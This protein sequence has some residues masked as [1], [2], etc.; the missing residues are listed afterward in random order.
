MP[1]NTRL[2]A[3]IHA[4][5]DVDFFRIELSESALVLTVNLEGGN[6]RV[7][8]V[9][10]RLLDSN[11]VELPRERDVGI[12]V[13]RLDAGI[14]YI[15]A[16]VPSQQYE[17]PYNIQAMTIPD[18]GDTFES[19]A[20]LNLLADR[21]SIV[22]GDLDYMIYGDFH[23]PDDVDFFKV[24]LSA[25]AE[26]TIDFDYP[27]WW[28]DLI[29]GLGLM[30]SVNL[31][32]FDDEGNPLHP[33]ISGLGG[34]GNRAYSLEAGT[35]YFRLST[36]PFVREYMEDPRPGTVFEYRLWLYGNAEYAQ[37]IDECSSVETD[38]DDP[39]VGCQGHL[40]DVNVEDV[41]A[42]NKGEGINI[43]VVDRTIESAHPDLRDNVKE[44]LNHD[45]TEADQIIN[46]RNSHATA[47]AGIIAARD[48]AL[49]VRGVAGIEDC[50][51]DGALRTS[52][53]RMLSNEL[54]PTV[55]GPGR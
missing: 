22:S 52:D 21:A 30:I 2:E 23:S 45:Y 7:Y 37:F 27:V 43:A 5:D 50:E 17:G 49:G 41:W 55:S 33:P 6:R 20:P 31:D 48:N 44:T 46:P 28:I 39:L 1:L 9:T 19:A 29:Y 32:A 10:F 14:Y 13:R 25:D 16:V 15:K 47:V 53:G 51:G 35:Y 18:H 42:T 34:D 38:F 8:N 11:G 26:V 36:P 4:P 40:P 12:P 3:T 54:V 24:E